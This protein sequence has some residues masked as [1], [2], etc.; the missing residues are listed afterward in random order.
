MSIVQRNQI[1]YL[2][3]LYSK[4]SVVIKYDDTDINKFIKFV[5]L[6]LKLDEYFTKKRTKTIKII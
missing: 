6:K 3:Y 2:Y 1:Y 4:C 5:K